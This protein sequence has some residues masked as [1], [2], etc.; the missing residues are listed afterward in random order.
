MKQT[1]KTKSELFNEMYRLGIKNLTGFHN[2]IVIDVN[3]ITSDD[4]KSDYLTYYWVV[5]KNGTHLCITAY[6]AAELA[7]SWKKE[8]IFTA[9]I[10]KDD[11]GYSL[12]IIEGKG[13]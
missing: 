13:E 3:E 2:D 12:K 7:T 1:F 4:E 11:D 8:Y 6:K 5:R 9:L 10:R